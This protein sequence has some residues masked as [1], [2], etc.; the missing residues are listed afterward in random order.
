MF[1]DIESAEDDQVKLLTKDY[2]GLPDEWQVVEPYV[3]P[4]LDEN[5][6]RIDNENKLYFYPSDSFCK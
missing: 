6:L 3:P 5:E 1:A 2:L 4:S